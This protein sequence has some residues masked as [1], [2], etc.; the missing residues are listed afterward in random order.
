MSCARIKERHATLKIVQ[1]AEVVVSPEENCFQAKQTTLPFLFLLHA[2]AGR[3][4]QLL[5]VLACLF[6]RLIDAEAGRLLAR[7][8]L[9]KRLEE[10]TYQGLGGNKHKH[11]VRRPFA[12]EDCRVNVSALERIAANVEE[13]REAQPNER[14]LPD[15]HSRRPLLHEVDLPLIN[16]QRQQIA[17]VAPVHETLARILFDLTFQERQQ[18]VTVN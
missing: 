4:G 3:F 17:I 12:I 7:R 5:F 1:A 6:E 13:L 8:E 11:S 10:F 18:V 14:L 15:A 16:A 2:S 9:F